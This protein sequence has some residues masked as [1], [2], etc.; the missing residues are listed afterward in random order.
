MAVQI[1]TA[2]GILHVGQGVVMDLRFGIDISGATITAL[3]E[4]PDGTKT[5]SSGTIIDAAAG[6]ADA[7]VTAAQLDQ[8]GQWTIQGKSQVGASDPHYGLKVFF[9]VET[10]IE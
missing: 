6:K 7:T 1:E 5:T 8:A 10:N 2:A 4:K 9:E 3:L